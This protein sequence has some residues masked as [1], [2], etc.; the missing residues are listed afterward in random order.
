[1]TYREFENC[2]FNIFLKVFSG[3]WKPL[4][5]YQ[6]FLNGDIRFT[7]LWRELPKVSKKVLLEQL[8][9]LELSGIVQRTQ[10]NTFPPEVFYGLSETGK[11]ILP[12][13][14]H[15]EEWTKETIIKADKVQSAKTV[16]GQG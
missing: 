16:S 9:E 15:I 2:P 4:I 7:D 5:L 12:V 8:K 11:T 6:F 14:L 3:K 10:V 1:M 13:I